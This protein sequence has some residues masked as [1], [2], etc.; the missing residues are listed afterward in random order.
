MIR[1]T[2]ILIIA[3][4]LAGAGCTTVDRLGDASGAQRLAV[5]CEA[6][7]GALDSLATLRADGALSESQIERVDAIR[8]PVTRACA[9]DAPTTTA[10]IDRVQRATAEI[11]EIQEDAQ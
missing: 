9:L 7:A 2:A 4:T 8:G 1:I 5:A 6:W 11:V 10:D 3:L